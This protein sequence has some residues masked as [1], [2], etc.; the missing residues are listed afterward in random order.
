M[1]SST[2]T[3]LIPTIAISCRFSEAL[4][5]QSR[6]A[7]FV[8]FC[9]VS[10]LFS[11][12]S[13]FKSSPNFAITAIRVGY[14]TGQNCLNI[15]QKLIFHLAEHIQRTTWAVNTTTATP[16]EGQQ[17]SRRVRRIQINKTFTACFKNNHEQMR[18]ILFHQCL[19]TASCTLCY[20]LLCTSVSVLLIFNWGNIS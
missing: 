12:A 16:M 7:S 5:V 18:A 11:A 2:C 19:S 17:Y 15:S 20:D 8:K 1:T 10:L 4:K 9:I 14:K 3:F 13:Q 6:S